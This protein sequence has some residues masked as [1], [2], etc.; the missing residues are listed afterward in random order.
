MENAVKRTGSNSQQ[1]IAAPVADFEN[2]VSAMIGGL[3]AFGLALGGYTLGYASP[4]VQWIC[5]GVL[6][7]LGSVLLGSGLRGIL[8]SRR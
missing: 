4:A 5:T 1:A 2:S 7:L 3:L 6:G 8:K